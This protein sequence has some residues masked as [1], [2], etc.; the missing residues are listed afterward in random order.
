M[1]EEEKEEL[2][3][4]LSEEQQLRK[5]IEKHIKARNEAQMEVVMHTV[6]FLFINIWLFGF[7]GWISQ[8]LQGSITMP[9]FITMIWGFMLI[10]HIL[11]YSNDHGYGY[12]RR[13]RRI[14]K[15]YQRLSRL[16]A[17]KRKNDHLI[18]K[19]SN[20]SEDQ[21]VYLDE[22]GEITFGKKSS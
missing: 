17:G 19:M 13:Q 8:I 16:H 12:D 3:E 22:D 9:S 10:V 2:K 20:L 15:E 18:D 6:F 7:G 11:N 4:F 21:E 5:K 1:D 14:E